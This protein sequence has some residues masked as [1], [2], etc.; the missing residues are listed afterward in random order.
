MRVVWRPAAR[1]DRLRIVAWLAERSP[2]SAI[3]VAQ[4]L[5]LAARSLGAFP[6]RGR[7]GLLPGTREIWSVRPYVIVYRVEHGDGIVEILRVWHGAQD[8]LV[9]E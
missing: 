3:R 8:R 2:A 4:A 9:S 5:R 6:D 7:P 1:A